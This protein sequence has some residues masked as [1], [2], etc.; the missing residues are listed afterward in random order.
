MNRS[1]WYQ[2]KH[3]SP[4]SRGEEE[5]IVKYFLRNGG[6][7]TKGGNTVWKKMEEDWVCP[8]RT[9]HSLKERFDKHIDPAL[10]KFGVSRQRLLDRDRDLNKSADSDRKGG[11]AM[12]NYSKQEDL[13]IINFICENKRFSDVKGNELW[14]L[15]EGRK[16]V[17]GRSWQ[18][19]KERYRKIILKN[20]NNYKLDKDVVAMFASK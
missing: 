10:H 18:S 3:R 20:I 1:Y 13:K 5:T 15:M 11:K 4:F 6:Y 16:V 14:K 9:W 12:R 2:A 7:S 17:E 8:G 19:L